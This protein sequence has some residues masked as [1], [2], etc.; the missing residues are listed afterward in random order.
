VQRVRE[1]PQ[2][3]PLSKFNT[4]A[5]ASR[6]AAGNKAVVDYT[7]PA[8]CTPVNPFRAISDAAYRQRAGGDLSHRQRQHAQKFGKDRTYGSE[9]ILAD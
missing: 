5:C 3:R 6:N 9:G 7:S 2:N 1:K 4:G 8:L